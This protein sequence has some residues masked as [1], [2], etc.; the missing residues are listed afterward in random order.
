MTTEHQKTL[1]E[2]AFWRLIEENTDRVSTAARTVFAEA[3]AAACE[4][5]HIRNYS[6]G[7]G[8][9]EES[10]HKTYL[11]AAELTDRDREVLSEIWRAAL[12]AAASIDPDDMTPA[13][14]VIRGADHWYY[15]VIS[16][17]VE[18]VLR[19]KKR[20]ELRKTAA[21]EPKD[22]TDTPF[23]FTDTPF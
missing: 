10:M 7:P 8:H 22:F 20:E 2:E 5:N 12:S 15:R 6:A 23:D 9:Y 16:S 13:H 3:E 1:E 19:E 4:E 11:A 14:G 21:R 18:Y 17:L